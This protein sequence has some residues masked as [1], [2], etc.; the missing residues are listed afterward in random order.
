MGRGFVVRFAVK[1]AEPTGQALTLAR[2][3]HPLC[4]SPLWGGVGEGYTS[5]HQPH[6]REHLWRTGSN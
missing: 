3:V 5:K 6:E 4:P 2:V 1:S